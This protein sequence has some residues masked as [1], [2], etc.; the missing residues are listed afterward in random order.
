MGR[1][2]CVKVNGTLSSWEQV[3]SG[4]PQGSVLGPLLF[5]L[6]VNELPSL[7]SSKLLMFADDIK[8]YCRI[9]SPEDWL[10]LQRDINVLLRWSKYWLLSFNVAKCK[11]VHIGSALYVDNYCLNETQQLLENKTHNTST[12]F[13]V[14]HWKWN[15]QCLLTEMSA[16]SIVACWRDATQAL[17]LLPWLLESGT[18]SAYLYCYQLSGVSAYCHSLERHT[19]QALRHLLWLIESGANNVCY[20]HWVEYLHFV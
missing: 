17:H 13:T 20:C 16:L 12:A 1:Y 15:K 14:T 9:H 5:A 8:L 19:T 18:N 6:H 2:Q 4:V 3:S 11:V 10:I 7:V